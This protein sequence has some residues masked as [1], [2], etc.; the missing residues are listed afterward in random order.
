MQCRS[1]NYE[2]S[3]VV[4]TYANERTNQIIRRRECIKCGK[5][6]STQE[7]IRDIKPSTYKTSPPNKI[8]EKL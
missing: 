1:C 7:H 8:F 5:R 2:H 3:R 6:F 4:D